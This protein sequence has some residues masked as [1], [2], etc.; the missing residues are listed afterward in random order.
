MLARRA[1]LA[2]CSSNSSNNNNKNDILDNSGPTALS[3]TITTTNLG[4][5][6]PIPISYK[7]GQHEAVLK[8]KGLWNQYCYDQSN[9]DNDTFF[10]N[11]TAAKITQ[12][13]ETITFIP[14]MRSGPLP[15]LYSPMDVSQ[16]DLDTRTRP[17]VFARGG[18]LDW[19][20]APDAK[21]REAIV[22][23]REAFWRGGEASGQRREAYIAE[24]EARR[25]ARAVERRERLLARA[26]R[27]RRA[28]QK[29]MRDGVVEWQESQGGKE[30]GAETACTEKVRCTKAD[31]LL[32]RACGRCTYALA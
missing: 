22:L 4:P 8:S 6:A 31:V 25:E 2:T 17:V 23:K 26:E 14:S 11:E 7:V 16:M 13:F 15:P 30:A 9:G 27:E 29:A 3:T 32:D 5:T 28:K 18:A 1:H 12:G 19:S 24:M 21:A 20:L 10:P